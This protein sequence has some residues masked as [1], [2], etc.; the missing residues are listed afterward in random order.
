MSENVVDL[1]ENCAAARRRFK[2]ELKLLEDLRALENRAAQV[3]PEA[4][5][6]LHARTQPIETRL[7]EAITALCAQIEQAQ[8]VIGRVEEPLYREVLERR[9]LQ[10]ADFREIAEA[11]HYSE[12]H[13]RRMHRAAV[14]RAAEQNRDA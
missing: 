2:A 11:M 13:V 8:K 14:E 6:A 12:R 3:M 1:L 10:Q 7:S 4:G 9:Y 5:A